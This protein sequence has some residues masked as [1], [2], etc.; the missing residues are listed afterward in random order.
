M[1]TASG[2]ATGAQEPGTVSSEGDEA[3]YRDALAWLRDNCPESQRTP[4]RRE[5][6]V[7]GGRKCRFPSEDARTWLE[8]M[9]DRGWTAPT[10]PREYGGAGLSPER[11]R[12]LQRAMRELGCR[13]P[14]IGHGLWMLGP[15]L[16]EHG[17][18][19]QKLKH[20][21]GIARGEVR[22]CQGY[23]EPGAGSCS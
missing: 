7:Y 3:F 13:S 14:L 20:L 4:A 16:L 21:P 10:W 12:L 5:E 9:A 17:T 11:A 8:R 2:R 18:E 6:L 22:W 23:S 1:S 19:A 15:A